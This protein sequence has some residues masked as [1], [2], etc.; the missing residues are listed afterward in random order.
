MSKIRSFSRAWGEGLTW[1]GLTDQT[2]MLAEGSDVWHRQMTLE[3][4]FQV[5]ALRQ[6][7]IMN[8]LSLPIINQNPNDLPILVK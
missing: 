5:G 4:F 6:G 7:R 2:V 8:A 1:I 3:Q